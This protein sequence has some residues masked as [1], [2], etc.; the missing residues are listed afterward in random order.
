MRAFVGNLVE[1]T[2]Q[3]ILTECEALGRKIVHSI[4]Y[5]LQQEYCCYCKAVCEKLCST[6]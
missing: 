2:V 5:V 3:H 1:E 6:F 4:R